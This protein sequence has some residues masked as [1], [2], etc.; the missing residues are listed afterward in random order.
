MSIDY[1]RFL[2]W[3]ESRFDDVVIKGNEIKLNSIFCDDYKHHMWCNPSGGK[4]N[5]P[6]GVFHCW[7]TDRCGSLVTLIMLKDK[8]SYEESIDILGGADI[9]LAELEE[10]IEK[11][12]SKKENIEIKQILEIPS[13]TFVI[14]ELPDNNFYKIEAE[15][16]LKKRKIPIDGLMVCT[17]GEYKRRIVIPYYNR[18]DKLIYYNCRYMSNSNKIPRYMGPPK[19]IGV[20]KGDV[21]Y[22]KKWP[23]FTETIY[24]TEGEFDSIALNISK[25]NGAACGG[26]FLT[27]MQ[28]GIIL[29]NQ[30][31]VVLCFDNDVAGKT[32]I[33][34]IG[35]TLHKHGGASY[36]SPPT[37][38][39]DWNQMLESFNS[40]V[41]FEYVKNKIKKYD[42][43]EYELELF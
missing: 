25:L 38:F 7:K 6:N 33:K 36:V 12:F 20:G 3:C 34:T 24:L 13:G 4:K 18:D 26:K 29:S 8:C 22:F 30:F 5:I 19:E 21:L 39:K 10:E 23:D 16:Y 15:S 28:L 2:K 31:Y 35:N 27:E 41:I 43:L 14:T 42:P 40:N 37:S 11:M 1:N 32:A 9:S 17:T